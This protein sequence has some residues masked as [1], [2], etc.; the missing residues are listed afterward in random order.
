MD[1]NEADEIIKLSQNEN[2]FGPS[3][4]AL[5]AVREQVDSMNRYPE[6]HSATLKAEFA[7]HYG[8]TP[9][10]IF[11]CAG[12]VETLDI[13][14]RN[15]IKPGENLVIPEIT[16]VAYRLLARVFHVDT[17][18]A[19]MKDY[20]IDIDSVIEKADDKTKVI[21]IASPNNPTGTM[22]SESD[23]I[24]LL[25]NG[26]PE[27]YVVIDEAYGEYVSH[28]DY[29]DS[30]ELQKEFPN[31][32][33]LRTFSK[34]YGLAGL[35]VGYAI[36]SPSIISHFEYFQPPFTVNHLATVAASAAIKD[37]EFVEMSYQRNLESRIILERELP[38]LG[39]NIV[40]SQSNFIFTYFDTEEE[41]DRV[42]QYMEKNGIIARDTDYFGDNKA[43]RITIPRPGNCQKVIDCLAK[44]QTVHS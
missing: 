19:E 43:F 5:K 38:K 1:K 22:T 34:I 28:D 2:P 16:F 25:K 4:L 32:I 24:K 26:S 27:T 14:I 36:A 15:I 44:Y 9:E 40:P 23:L 18:Y 21:I 41:R 35:R 6:P 33:I 10:N 20:A 17:R 29:H 3:T 39:Y 7:N 30:L 13:L 42:H 8:L 11:V 12:L 37:E 31:L